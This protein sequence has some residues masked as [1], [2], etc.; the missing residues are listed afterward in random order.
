MGSE[1]NKGKSGLKVLKSGEVL[2]QD[3][4]HADSL[5]IIQKGQL[6]LYKP[7]GK[8]FV[9]LAVL[10]SG[11][12]IGEMAYFDD[13]D[14]N[15]KRSCA[16]SAMVETEVIEI[17]FAA[18]GKTMNSLNPWF[19]TIINTLASRLRKTNSKIKELESNSTSLSYGSG[20]VGGG[21][22]FLK[23]SD[24]LKILSTLYLVF[25]THGEMDE[26]GVVIHRKTIDLYTEEVYSI[27]E[28]KLDAVLFLLK[29]LGWIEIVDDQDKMPKLYIC[30]KVEY[31]KN[32]FIFYSTE[33]HLNENK[34]MKI[35]QN[36]E[37]LLDKILQY[38]PNNPIVEVAHL[39]K[40]DEFEKPMT[41]FSQRYVLNPI[42][43]EFKERNL[44]ISPDYLE[45][46][47][48]I[49]ITGELVIQEGKVLIEI[50]FP[51]LQKMYPIIKFSGMIN[52]LNREKAET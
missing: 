31:L 47:R 16:A 48:T 30:K 37:V 6:R 26:R 27:Q 33:K 41:R 28:A 10:R 35:S 15:R 44:P 39:K 21:Y 50:D 20:K 42:I 4:A 32:L 2:F 8:G 18:F 36:C 5:F 17:S 46:A 49:G 22:E 7:K 1:E 52:R 23:P 51:K 19:K 12:V 25:K 11:E 40:S 43:D 3:G 29:E 34:K 9:E 14:G 45:D 13:G 38:E 24:S